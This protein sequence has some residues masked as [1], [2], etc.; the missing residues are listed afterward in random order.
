MWKIF[1][2]SMVCMAGVVVIGLITPTAQ[3]SKVVTTMPTRLRGTWY[4]NTDNGYKYTYSFNN[5]S[6]KTITKN[7]SHMGIRLNLSWS[8]DLVVIR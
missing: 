3:A 7:D 5:H 4:L 1:V 2:K 8:K 6:I